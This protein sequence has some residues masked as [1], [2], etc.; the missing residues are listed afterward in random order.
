KLIRTKKHKVWLLPDGLRYTI[1]STPSDK[2]GWMNCLSDLRI[3][4][5]MSHENKTQLDFEHKKKEPKAKTIEAP[6]AFLDG[7]PE[8]EERPKTPVS[9][10]PLEQVNEPP[11]REILP[12][13]GR[14]P[15]RPGK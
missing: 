10:S 12:M 4:L 9:V 8:M 5:G 6:T 15:T 7:V 13:Y 2:R 11:E 1:P 14:F 3:K